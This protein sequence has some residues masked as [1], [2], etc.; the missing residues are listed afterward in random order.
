MGRPKEP[1]RNFPIYTQKWNSK[2]KPKNYKSITFSKTM[3]WRKI[4]TSI[5]TESLKHLVWEIIIFKQKVP[6]P[7][8]HESKLPTSFGHSTYQSWICFFYSAGGK[9]K[10]MKYTHLYNNEKISQE[11]GSLNRCKNIPEDDYQPA[12]TP[13]VRCCPDCS[14][15]RKNYTCTGKDRSRDPNKCFSR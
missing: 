6:T 11:T 7:Q 9:K 4:F 15:V 12:Q 10:N 2:I 13:N 1:L 5:G 8:L 14:E 3:F